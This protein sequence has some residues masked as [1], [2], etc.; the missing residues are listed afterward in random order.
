MSVNLPLLSLDGSPPSP[1]LLR[2]RAFSSE[3]KRGEGQEIW[4]ILP[5]TRCSCRHVGCFL[6]PCML[7]TQVKVWQVSFLKR[8]ILSLVEL[9]LFER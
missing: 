2:A 4:K 7:H 9:R 6:H 5:S 8:P 1:S 3:E